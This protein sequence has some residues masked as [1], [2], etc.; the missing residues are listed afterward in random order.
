MRAHGRL[1]I[2]KVAQD[3]PILHRAL[4]AETFDRRENGAKTN[5]KRTRIILSCSMNA[6]PRYI[7][8]MYDAGLRG[9][10]ESVGLNTK[11]MS[12]GSKHV[13][14]GAMVSFETWRA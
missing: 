13:R 10:M 9:V 2:G 1:V 12:P 8:Y 11:T 3:M 5:G 6:V 14:R 7:F 4:W